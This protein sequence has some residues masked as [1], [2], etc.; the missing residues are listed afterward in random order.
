MK[1]FLPVLLVALIFLGLKVSNGGIRLSDTNIY[2]YTGYQ[3]L[4]GKL[5]YKD[6]FFTNFPLLPYISALYFLIT[7]NNLT[8]FFLTAAIEAG[9]VGILISAIILYQYKNP[10]LALLCG[11]VYLFSFIT[12]TTSDHQTGV[13]IASVFAVSSYYAHLKKQ[14]I[15][16]GIFIALCLLTKA[17]FLPV[18]IALSITL[19]FQQR[20][21]LLR[22]LL[23]FAITALVVLSPSLLLAR[24]DMIK[25]II[26]YSLTRSQGVSKTNIA[27]FFI[28]RDSI[29]FILLLFNIIHFRK[30]LFFFVLSISTIIFFLLYK[31]VYYLYLNFVT[32]FLCLSLAPFVITLRRY[33][34]I[35]KMVIPTIVGILL[36]INLFIYLSSY[37]DL[38]KITIETLTKAITQEK[39]AYLYG[40]NDITPALAFFTHT[41]LL[42]NIIDTNENIYRKGF[43]NRQQLTS[44]AL[45][46]K[47]VIV[48]HG[49][50]YLEQ[51][52]NVP[53]VG[54]IFDEKRVTESCTLFYSLPVTT[55]GIENR[56]SLFK[57]Y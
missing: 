45:K 54:G 13:F 39:P 15:F 47:T 44:D 11:T 14:Y 2:F 25:D 55:E 10:R 19:F 6:I 26:S 57:C 12:L 20:N 22:Y 49:I 17:Y 48:A 32:P 37:R 53:L 27:W 7:G 51:N 30:N 1:K 43:L 8:L 50:T 28:K 56:I 4:Q 33:F 36:T 52:I 9:I 42:N 5:L 31:D 35:Q 40:V 16:S 29:L 21:A 38:Q 18:F 24:E 3:L 34:N 41:P 46:R 23:S